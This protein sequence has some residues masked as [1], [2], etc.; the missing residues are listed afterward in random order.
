LEDELN[1]LAIGECAEDGGADAAQSEGKAEEEAGHRADF[2][3]GT[4]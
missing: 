4:E 2:A 3:G 1:A